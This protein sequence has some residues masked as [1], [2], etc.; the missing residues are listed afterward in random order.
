MSKIITKRK[1]LKYPF[2]D[3]PFQVMETETVV[4]N[5]GFKTITVRQQRTDDS[6]PADVLHDQ[7]WHTDVFERKQGEISE[8]GFITFNDAEHK[9]EENGFE[10]TQKAMAYIKRNIKT[11]KW[12]FRHNICLIIEYEGRYWCLIK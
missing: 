1:R 10:T 2:K 9:H 7:I 4:Q 11:T 6:T 8:K 12:R 5:D 3:A